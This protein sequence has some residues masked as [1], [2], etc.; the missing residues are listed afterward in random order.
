MHQQGMQVCMRVCVYVCTFVNGDNSVIEFAEHAYMYVC[1]HVRTYTRTHTHTHSTERKSFTSVS[2]EAVVAHTYMCCTQTHV[3]TSTHTNTHTYIHVH[4]TEWKSCT[5]VN[6]EAFVMRDLQMQA[7]QLFAQAWDTHN[8]K[9]RYVCSCVCICMYELF[10]Q[11]WDCLYICA[12]VY[13]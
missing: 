11:A 6:G 1:T 13:I 2:G 3:Y 7:H 5:P 9:L 10:A 4:T 8:T 12:Y